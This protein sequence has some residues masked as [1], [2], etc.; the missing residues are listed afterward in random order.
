MTNFEKW[1]S[2]LTIEDLIN[3]NAYDTIALS[4]K[5]CPAYDNCT[6]GYGVCINNFYQ[7]A[8]QEVDE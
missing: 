1:K 8:E 6:A 7:W 4:C 2:E 3:N 5:N